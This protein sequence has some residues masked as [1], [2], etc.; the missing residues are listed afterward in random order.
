MKES[1]RGSSRP[2]YLMHCKNLCKCYNVS[3]PRTTIKKIKFL[4]ICFNLKNWAWQWT[5]NSRTGQVEVGG[6]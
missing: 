2:V 3:P 1:I 5:C 6:S 4:K